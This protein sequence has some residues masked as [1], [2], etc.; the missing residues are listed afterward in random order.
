MKVHPNCLLI[1]KPRQT[2]Y[3]LKTLLNVVLFAGYFSLIIVFFFTWHPVARSNYCNV[4]RMMSLVLSAISVEGKE[5]T[6]NPTSY[7]VKIFIN[8]LSRHFNINCLKSWRC[9]LHYLWIFFILNI[10]QTSWKIKILINVSII[11]QVSNN[12]SCLRVK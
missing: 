1:S 8:T 11:I 2:K 5:N 3:E 9:F 12:L 6:V 4:K 10:G 7:T